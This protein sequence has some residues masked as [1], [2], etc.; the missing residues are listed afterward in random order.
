ME[1]SKKSPLAYVNSKIKEL[2]KEKR[3]SQIKYVIFSFISFILNIA[4]IG[5]SIYCIV[6]I[7]KHNNSNTTATILAALSAGLIVVLFALNVLNVVSRGLFKTRTYRQA[8]F[9]MQTETTQFKYNQ[10]AYKKSEDKEKLYLK[11]IKKI[12][13][14][15]KGKKSKVKLMTILNA[16]YWGT[17]V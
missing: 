15:A 14:N 17:Y 13:K 4:T 16:I 10:N 6:L 11:N 7:S 9:A 8:L 1:Q 3:S 12:Y 2:E 5:L